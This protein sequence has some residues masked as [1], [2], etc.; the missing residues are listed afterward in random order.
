VEVFS[1]HRGPLEFI[2]YQSCFTAGFPQ[3]QPGESVWLHSDLDMDAR[4][5]AVRP[6]GVLPL[7]LSQFRLVS[8]KELEDSGFVQAVRGGRKTSAAEIPADNLLLIQGF[9]NKA[10]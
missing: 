8:F 6:G 9:L 5:R 2:V 4:V 7:K 1:Q 3:F 10:P